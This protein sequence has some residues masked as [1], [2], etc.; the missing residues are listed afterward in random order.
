MNTNGMAQLRAR[1]ETVFNDKLIDFSK[2]ADAE[3]VPER[4]AA[5]AAEDWFTCEAETDGSFLWCCLVLK[6]SPALTRD[7]VFSRGRYQAGVV[8]ST[9][10]PDV[11]DYAFGSDALG[12]ID[13][14]DQPDAE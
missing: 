3:T 8:K 7:Y 9:L 12:R 14:V 10:D 1:A 5:H 6:I 4:E 11:D 2:R 13:R